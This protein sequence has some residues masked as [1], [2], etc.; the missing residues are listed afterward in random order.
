MAQVL[1]RNLPDKTVASLKSRAKRNRRSLQA[2][3]RLILESAARPQDGDW[4][5]ALERLERMFAGRAFRDSTE[6]IRADRESH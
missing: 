5:E 4:R 1:V 6:L 2:E 3:L